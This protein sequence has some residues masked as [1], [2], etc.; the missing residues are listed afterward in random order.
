MRLIHTKILVG[1]I[2]A[3]VIIS[4]TFIIALAG[5]DFIY[6]TLRVDLPVVNSAR[7]YQVTL[8]A[9]DI[10]SYGDPDYTAAWLSINLDIN[11][12][13]TFPDQFSQIGLLTSSTGVRWFVYAEPGVICLRGTTYWGNLGC[14]GSVNDIASLNSWYKV[15]L[16]TYMEGFWIARIYDTNNVSYD[17]AKILSPSIYIYQA[18]SATEEAYNVTQDPYMTAAF[19]H[20]HPQ[21]MVWGSGFQDWPAS[22]NVGVSYMG[23]SD[24]SGNNT[25]CPDYYGY[26]PNPFDERIWYAGSSYTYKELCQGFLFPSVHIFLPTIKK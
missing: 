20:S 7:D 4:Q 19:N 17:V 2:A 6:A 9:K 16:V 10:P 8:Y 15:E 14:R 12:Q 26:N 25:F 11:H 21:Y 24:D 5:H 13:P 1:I 23:S 3:I 22:D 18:N